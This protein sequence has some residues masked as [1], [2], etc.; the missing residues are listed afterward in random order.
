MKTSR[1]CFTVT[2]LLFLAR[3]GL[4][5]T[6][7]LTQH[8]DNYRTG[9]NNKET[10]LT[11]S[12][13]TTGKFAKLFTRTVDDQ[14]YSQ[15]LVATGINIPAVGVKNVVFVTTVNNSI[16]AFDADDITAA[17]PYWHVNLTVAGMR[18]TNHSDMQPPLCGLNYRDFSGNIGIVGTPVIDKASGTLYV[19]ARSTNG[20]VFQQWLHALDL[21]TGS[22]K[23]SPVQITAQVPGTGDNAGSIV[24]T[25]VNF[26]PQKQNQRPGLL[27]LNGIVYI[28]YASHCDWDYYHGWLLGYDA[29]TLQQKIIYNTTPNALRGGIWM[30]GAGPAA[31]SLGNIYV[32]TGNGEDGVN[33]SEE[34]TDTT[35]R[36]ESALKLMPNSTQTALS[37]ST[38]FRPFNFETLDGSDDLDFGS[39]QLMLIPN[40]TRAIA[41]CKNGNLYLLNRDNMGGYNAGGP[42]NDAQTISLGTSAYM[43]ASLAYYKGSAA[44]S[45]FLFSENTLLRSFP[46]SGGN[47][48]FLGNPTLSGIIG[49]NNAY[50]GAFLSVSSNGSEDSTA[51]L[52]ISHSDNGCNA[53]TAAPSCP[54]ILRAVS[55]TNVTKEL[56]NSDMLT[57]DSVGQYAKNV[58]PTVANG[59]IY[60]ATLSGRLDVYGLTGNNATLCSNPNVALHAS[61][62]ASSINP[63]G[64]TP[65]NAFDG[66]LSTN[67]SS[68][69]TDVENLTVD[70]GQTY[71][72]CGITIAWGVAYGKNF[73]IEISADDASW[74]TL[75]SVTANAAFND[76]MVV[77]GTGRYVRMQGIMSGTGTGY[78]IKEMQVLGQLPNSCPAPTGISLTNLMQTS[79]DISW[80]AIAGAS[81]YL[82]TVTTISSGNRTFPTTNTN[83]ISLSGLACGSDYTVTIQAFCSGNYGLLSALAPFTTVQC[84]TVCLLPTRW[85]SKDVGAVGIAGSSCYNSGT[86]SLQGSGAGI[87]GTS[88]AFQY[89]EEFIE[90]DESIVSRVVSLSGTSAGAETGIMIREGSDPSSRYALIALNAGGGVTFSYRNATGGSSAQVSGINYPSLPYWV[91][92]TVS[93]TEYSGFVSSDGLNWMPIGSSVNLGFGTTSGTGMDGLVITSADNTVSANASVDNFSQSTSALPVILLNFTGQ[94]VQDEYNALQWSTSSEVN[95]GYFEVQRSPDGT[96]YSPL[97][98]V[99]ASGASTTVQQYNFEDPKPFQGMNNYRL[100]MVDLDGKFSYSPVVSVLFGK[101][102]AP[103]VFPNPVHSSLTALAGIDAIRELRVTDATG[104]I[105]RQLGNQAGASSITVY[106]GDLA[107]GV[108]FVQVITGAR[109]YQYKIIKE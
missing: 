35:N 80:Q 18:P 52:W 84:G 12:N 9:W 27:L 101:L 77:T 41:G 82:L 22:D 10:I 54:G 107:Q 55:A 7:V 73:N 25:V 42:D 15:P 4:G 99:K 100:K 47:N 108:Y 92:L 59:K 90:E 57:S 78:S 66:N 43:H 74:T 65:A 68:N 70:L 62:T 19:V 58:C 61:A 56:W 33:G 17:S 16:Y 5:Q 85:S 40:S 97:G 60:L 30:S 6:D 104:T 13:V 20:T 8:N 1:L 36:G 95:S 86:Y 3:P 32:A 93:G 89:A 50:N 38:Y 14:T 37:V 71:N 69:P 23:V 94:N 76:S 46:F 39:T 28:A 67:W 29:T 48:G 87:G 63:A 2:L 83:S 79:V 105:L 11:T 26:D 75:D 81:S 64:N 102:A 72:V 51:I 91:G 44:E 45:I 49:P 98:T 21:T 53:N 88:D 34:Q 31:D 109:T 96:S 24:N 106:T 103:L